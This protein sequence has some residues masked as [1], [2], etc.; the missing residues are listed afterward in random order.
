MN[1]ENLHYFMNMLFNTC[2]LMVQRRS[3]VAKFYHPFTPMLIQNH[4]ALLFYGS[5][6]KVK[7]FF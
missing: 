7:Q 6:L 5:N 1:E 2:K 4:E 3:D